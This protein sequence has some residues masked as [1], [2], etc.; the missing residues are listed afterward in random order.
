MP[1]RGR[2]VFVIGPD[3]RVL[4]ARVEPTVFTHQNAE[5]VLRVLDGVEALR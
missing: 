5:A 2:G 4:Y 1:G 3:R